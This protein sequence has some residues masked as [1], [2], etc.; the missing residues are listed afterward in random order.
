MFAAV[1]AIYSIVGIFKHKLDHQ[2]I[3][4]NDY[5][6]QLFPLLE[7]VMLKT[8]NQLQNNFSDTILQQY[9]DFIKWIR[10]KKGGECPHVNG[11]QFQHMLL[12]L[13]QGVKSFQVVNFN[14]IDG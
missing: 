14:N 12:V 11:R 6:A 3:S 5:M 8:L 4:L 2:R 10:N 9:V 7:N 1:Y 13:I